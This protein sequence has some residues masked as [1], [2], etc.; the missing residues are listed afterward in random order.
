MF[1]D[2]EGQFAIF[3]YDSRKKQLILARD[4][5]GIRPLFFISNKKFFSFC[6]EIKGL[7]QLS[8][9]SSSFD[10]FALLFAAFVI[11]YVLRD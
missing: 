9:V 2:F 7:S 4:P 8:K 10:K 1:K 3:I 5:Y 11:D 6:S